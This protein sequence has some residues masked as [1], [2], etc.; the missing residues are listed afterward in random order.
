M[1]GIVANGKWRW[2]FPPRPRIVLAPGV[3]GVTADDVS[4]AID[5]TDFCVFCGAPTSGCAR[6]LRCEKHLGE[7]LDPDCHRTR[8]GMCARVGAETFLFDTRGSRCYDIPPALRIAQD[9][10]GYGWWL[11]A[12]G[13]ALFCRCCLEGCSGDRPG[14][15]PFSLKLLLDQDKRRG[16]RRTFTYRYRYHGSPGRWAFG[17]TYA[18]ET[19]VGQRVECD[20]DDQ[21]RE[22]T[23]RLDWLSSSFPD[24]HWAYFLESYLKRLQ[25]LSQSR[26]GFHYKTG[27]VRAREIFERLIGRNGLFS[28]EVE[29][30]GPPT[31]YP[32]AESVR[33]P[34]SAVYRLRLAP[35]D[36]G[37]AFVYRALYGAHGALARR[38]RL[39]D[40]DCG[41]PN[42]VHMYRAASDADGADRLGL[43]FCVPVAKVFSGFRYSLTMRGIGNA[44]LLSVESPRWGSDMGG[45][46]VSESIV[47]RENDGLISHIAW[48]A[49]PLAL[50]WCTVGVAEWRAVSFGHLDGCSALTGWTSES[51][52][53]V[54][55]AALRALAVD[56]GIRFRIEERCRWLRDPDIARVRPIVVMN[57]GE[58]IEIDSRWKRCPCGCGLL[59]RDRERCRF[60][61]PGG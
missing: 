61:G 51:R 4:G 43:A 39:A 31:P 20:I 52:A 27:V 26:G 40:A 32:D 44:A 33:P 9:R 13:T 1:S 21:F 19:R 11:D 16:E 47:R 8:R 38:L 15:K 24:R 18:L 50:P 5:E 46:V 45:S 58:P 55:S 54:D 14:D 25:R 12:G 10:G 34:L 57:C 35:R 3:V 28:F 6:R 23:D 7:C 42:A 60:S 59:I 2:P 30:S 22:R 37:M 41:Q 17:M 56:S 48:Q 36:L 49:Q 29:Q 53:L